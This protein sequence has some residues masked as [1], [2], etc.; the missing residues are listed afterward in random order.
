MTLPSDKV[1]ARFLATLEIVRRELHVLEY[2]WQRL[3]SGTINRKWVESLDQNMVVAEQLEAFVSRFGRLQDT[4]GDKLIPR[5]LVA[6]LEKPESMLDNLNRAE[7]LGW[8]N[9]VTD[10]VFIRELRNRLVH[11]YM[12]ESEKFAED[13]QSAGDFV[14]ELREVYGRILQLAQERFGV[15]ESEL[16]GFLRGKEVF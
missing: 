3:F 2:S 9:E 16:V 13:I 15:S 6:E 5:A 11:E 14:P 12:V 10:W 1:K 7:R 4:I 8:I